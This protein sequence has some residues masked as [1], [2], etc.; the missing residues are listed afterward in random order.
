MNRINEAR[1]LYS[2][3]EKKF[4]G[5]ENTDFGISLW[6]ETQYRIDESKDLRSEIKDYFKKKMIIHD[7]T[8]KNENLHMHIM[9]TL[10]QLSESVNLKKKYKEL[11]KGLVKQAKVWNKLINL[12]ASTK[13]HTGYKINA[14]L[15]TD[16]IEIHFKMKTKDSIRVTS[17]HQISTI[18]RALKKANFAHDEKEKEILEF[19]YNKLKRDTA[20]LLH[21][22]FE[23]QTD[24]KI[25]NTTTNDKICR[26]I[27]D[28]FIDTGIML[29]GDL[30][31]SDIEDYIRTLIFRS[32]LQ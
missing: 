7:F 14:P 24:I 16:I 1:E 26:I 5:F 2:F 28:I 8:L 9:L 22:Y 19:T 18:I 32:N 6:L 29:P 31:D 17:K 21:Y 3:F 25:K 11:F 10:F 20:K 4:S 30:G 23:K 15:S 12:M 27:Y 13:L